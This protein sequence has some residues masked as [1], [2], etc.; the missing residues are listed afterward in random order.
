MQMFSY[1][2]IDIPLHEPALQASSSLIRKI[3]DSSQ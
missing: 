3:L 1:V 2:F